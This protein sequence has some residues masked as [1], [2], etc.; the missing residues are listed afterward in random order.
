MKAGEGFGLLLHK[1]SI[2]HIFNSLV[3]IVHRNESLDYIIIII[4]FF[5]TN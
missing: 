3:K 4:K 1:S 5:L 2:I